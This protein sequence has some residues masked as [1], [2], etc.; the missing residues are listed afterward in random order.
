[1]KKFDDGDNE[2]QT[3]RGG[4]DRL[5]DYSRH[6][7]INDYNL[8]CSEILRWKNLPVAESRWVAAA[9]KDNAGRSREREITRIKD[10]TILSD[11]IG[12]GLVTV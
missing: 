11:Y 12:N 7:E 1:M 6:R 2:E 3:T 8:C 10:H 4:A 5:S 9:M